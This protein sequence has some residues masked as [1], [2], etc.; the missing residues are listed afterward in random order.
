MRGLTTR[1]KVMG[2]W[3]WIAEGVDK[4]EGER[5]EEEDELDDGNGGG[6]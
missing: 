3:D 4:A 5:R 1:V 2:V 6:I